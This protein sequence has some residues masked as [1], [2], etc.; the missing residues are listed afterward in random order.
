MKPPMPGMPR[1]QRQ[2]QVHGSATLPEPGPPA[3]SGPEPGTIFES[4]EAVGLG[5][6]ELAGSP[7]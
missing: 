2:L 6:A 7:F 1:S 3:D 5:I 4:G